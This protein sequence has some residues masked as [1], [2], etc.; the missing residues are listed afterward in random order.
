MPH[1]T[2]AIAS[3]ANVAVGR[4]V[5]L[6]RPDAAGM[7][8][9]ADI[10]GTLLTISEECVGRRAVLSVAGEVDISNA[11]DL[12]VAIESA[13][14][15]AFEMWLDLSALT[16]MDSSGLHAMAEARVRLLEA[17]T[18]LTL[19]CPEGPVLRLLAL[20]GFDRIFEIHASR[21]A[22]NHATHATAHAM[23]RGDD[24][25]VEV[26]VGGDFDMAATFKL[27][28]EVDRLLA[29]TRVRRL[30]VDLAEARFID[31]AGVGALL[32]IRERTEQ[33][34]VELILANVPDPVQRV[35]DLTGTSTVLAH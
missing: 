2:R 4:P 14:T 15:R 13:A 9:P 28:P 32:S 17:N 29:E 20:T 25:C 21:S 7:K 1:T 16:F 30:V 24:T 22:A 5:A 26:A 6:A 11:T 19:I 33:L 10:N 27:E 3:A 8:R 35:L 23:P 31:S 34:G 18:R 12:R